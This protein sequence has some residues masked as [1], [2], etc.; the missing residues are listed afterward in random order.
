MLFRADDS[1]RQI[2]LSMYRL[3]G[4]DVATRQYES[5]VFVA[6][7]GHENIRRHP[8]RQ[9][10]HEVSVS[11]TQLKHGAYLFTL[12][13]H[14]VDGVAADLDSRVYLYDGTNFNE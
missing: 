13:G 14:T 1:Y 2:V 6:S 4:F 7:A 5:R 8:D 9:Y 11:Y 3:E 12:E 10:L